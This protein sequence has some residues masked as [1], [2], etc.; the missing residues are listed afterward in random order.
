MKTFSERPNARI[1]VQ[2]LDAYLSIEQEIKQLNKELDV[3][4]NPAKNIVPVVEFK[5]KDMTINPEMTQY[6][7]QAMN[8]GKDLA[9][10]LPPGFLP[11]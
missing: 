4:K 2:D 8:E 10:V 11:Q 1:R 6:I 3:L 7:I 5:P 9:D